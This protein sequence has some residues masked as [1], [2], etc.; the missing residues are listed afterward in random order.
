MG[1]NKGKTNAK[2]RAA[3]RK[4]TERLQ[5]AKQKSS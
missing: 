1:H 4:K 2:K 3:R 5:A